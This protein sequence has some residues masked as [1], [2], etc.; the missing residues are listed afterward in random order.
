MIRWYD[1]YIFGSLASRISPLFYQAETIR[2]HSSLIFRRLRVGCCSSVGALFF[3]RI[4]D[5]VG[6]KYAFLDTLLIMSGATASIGFL[7][8]MQ[9][10]VGG[11]D[12]PG[13][14]YPSGLAL[15]GGYWRRIRGRACTGSST[16]SS[17]A[18]YRCGNVRT[19]RSLVVILTVQNSA[20]KLQRLG[21]AHAFIVSIFLVGISLY[22]RLRMKSHPS[23]ST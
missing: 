14:S 13:Y 5:L 4:G 3:G 19:V 22:I 21:L 11:A 23:F 15:G 10:R 1:F 6:R 20:S 9:R 16:G 17:Q 7:R 12:T 18:S 8:R 2:W